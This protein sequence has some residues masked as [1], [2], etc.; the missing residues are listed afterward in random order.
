MATIQKQLCSDFLMNEWMHHAD[1]NTSYIQNNK[2]LENHD[3]FGQFVKLKNQNRKI[4]TLNLQLWG[5][6]WFCYERELDFPRAFFLGG[7]LSAS[8]WGGECLRLHPVPCSS[9]VDEMLVELLDS[10]ME[11]TVRW[12]YHCAA[13]WLPCSLIHDWPLWSV[14]RDSLCLSTCLSVSSSS[15]CR[16]FSFAFSSSR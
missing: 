7:K 13:P 1:I 15:L 10:L 9:L 11:W 4:H 16:V 3:F 2:K 12:Q 8:V 6:N 14:K 5:N